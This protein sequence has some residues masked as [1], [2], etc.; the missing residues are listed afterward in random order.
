MLRQV[1]YV[2]DWWKPTMASPRTIAGLVK[3]SD[4]QMTSGSVARTFVNSHS[5]NIT[6]L[7]CGLST[8]KMRTPWLIQRRTTRSTSRE[9]PAKSLSK[10]SG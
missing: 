8:R 9:S 6:G 7:V 2:Y 4:S 5:Q 10:F 3:A 1:K